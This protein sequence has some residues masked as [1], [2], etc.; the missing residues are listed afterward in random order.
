MTTVRSDSAINCMRKNAIQRLKVSTELDV[1]VLGGGVNGAAVL[2]ELALNGLSAGLIDTGDFCSGASGASSRMAH[3]GLR[4]LEG[5]E[6]RLVAESTAERDRLFQ[7]AS[8]FVRPLEVVVPLPSLVEGL[9]LSISRF[10]NLTRK[11]GPLSLVAL[12]GALT[13]Y[14]NLGRKT[15]LLPRHKTLLRRAQFPKGIHKSTRAVTSYFDGQITQPEALIME[16]LLESMTV[17]AH[18]FVL[19]HVA[20]HR[21][22]DTI[23]IKDNW[24]MTQHAIRPR[25][26]VNATGAWIDR[27]NADLGISTHYLRCIKGAHLVLNHSVLSQR[28]NQRAFYFDD[29]TG[30][31]V[32]ALPVG[33]NV[34]VGTTE[35][36][37][38]DPDDR[39]VAN[40]EIDYLIGAI[41]ALFDDIDVCQSQIV[42][43]TTGIRPLRRGSGGSA[44]AAARDHAQE[45][46]LIPDTSMAVMSLVGGKWTTFRA[47]AEQATNE[48]LNLLEVDRQVSTATRDF[49]GASTCS[50]AT[51]C[52]T[53]N[54]DVGR[55]AVLKA[56]YGSFAMDVAHYCRAREDQPVPGSESYSHAEIEWLITQRGACTIEDIVLRRTQ[57]TLGQGIRHETLLYLGNIL[58]SA[59]ERD[60]DAIKHEIALAMS[61]PLLRGSQATCQRAA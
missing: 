40:S 19:N 44:T 43:M 13:L 48:L 61:N 23:V 14:E 8:H 27:V 11:R 56:R 9:V 51:L 52:M 26:I 36:E 60:P 5:R 45:V 50:L 58:I 3:G 33:S 12:K 4:Y 41:N 29:S 42:S 20:W 25:M 46:D 35:V 18:V 22:G 17:N 53:G 2:R 55:A 10:L 21:D 30:R 38:D 6:F 7:H 31:M 34:L 28:M 39:S 59:A 37:I 16:M 15:G 57:M 47:F 24:G 1:L 49:P 54:T 32:V